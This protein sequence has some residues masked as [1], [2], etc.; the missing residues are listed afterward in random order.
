MLSKIDWSDP[1][2][3]GYDDPIYGRVAEAQ[4][5]IVMWRDDG[6]EASTYGC[7]LDGKYHPLV[8]PIVGAMEPV[9]KPIVPRFP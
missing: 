4:P 9:V 3:A 1:M 7:W 6:N 5:I 2:L 8:R